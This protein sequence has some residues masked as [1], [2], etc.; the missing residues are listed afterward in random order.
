[1]HKISEQREH[2]T[3]Q[4]STLT[5]AHTQ[6]LSDI[7]DR[8]GIKM[9]RLVKGFV[10]SSTFRSQS[11]KESA[12]LGTEPLKPREPNPQTCATAGWDPGPLPARCLPAKSTDTRRH[13][14]GLLVHHSIVSKVVPACLCLTWAG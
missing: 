3:P 12:C 1:V 2:Q 5:A 6:T 4:Y 9:I 14:T 10:N 7:P 13:V 11:M 8:A